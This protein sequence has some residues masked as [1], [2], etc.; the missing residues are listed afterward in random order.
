MGSIYPGGRRWG[1]GVLKCCTVGVLWG[2][3]VLKCCTVCVLWGRGVLKCCAVCGLWG[4]RTPRNSKLACRMLAG[5]W[6][7]SRRMD[8]GWKSVELSSKCKLLLPR[9]RARDNTVP[10]V[11]NCFED[12][13]HGSRDQDPG[14]DKALV[15]SLGS[16]FVSLSADPPGVERVEVSTVC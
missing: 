11:Y 16:F 3:G 15:G 9:F 4:A 14:L 8:T 13:L 1:R 7:F 2:R 6:I 5:W 10:P 12:C